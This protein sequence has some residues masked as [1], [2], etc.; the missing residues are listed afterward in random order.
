MTD[1]LR[2][3]KIEQNARVLRYVL[4]LD[5]TCLKK[6]MLIEQDKQ[7]DTMQCTAYMYIDK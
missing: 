7:L 2:E 5:M 6:V 1:E 3:Q 4:K